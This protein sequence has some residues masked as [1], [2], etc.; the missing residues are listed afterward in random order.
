MMT[1]QRE[2]EF[3]RLAQHYSQL[4]LPLCI[5]GADQAQLERWTDKLTNYSLS[6]NPEKL[7]H[8]EQQE[9]A[10]TL[11]AADNNNRVFILSADPYTLVQQ[12]K[13]IPALAAQLLTLPL[14]IV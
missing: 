7:S 11:K 10:A 6:Y 14:E 2:K 13:L 1:T 5:W 8:K 12:Q 4:S 3:D 9:L